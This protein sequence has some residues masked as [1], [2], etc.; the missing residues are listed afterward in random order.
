MSKVFSGI[1]RL[2]NGDSPRGI[3]KGTLVLE[4]GAFRGV[5]GEGVLDAMLEE[6]LNLETVIG[7]SAGALNGLNYA[8]GQIG[9]SARINLRYRHDPRYVGRKALVNNHGVIGF[10]FVFGEFAR[11]VDIFNYERFNESDHR[12]LAVATSLE[13]GR[14]V[15][16]ERGRCGDIFKAIQASA[17]MPYI[18]EPVEVD[19]LKCLDGGCS[20]KIPYA[21]ALENEGAEGRVVIVKTLP[22]DYRRKVKPESARAAHLVYGKSHPEFA[23]VLASS[24]ERANA[25]CDEIDELEKQ[26]RAFVIAPSRFIKVGRLE[27]DMEKLGALYYLGYND[28]KARMAE[29]KEYLGVRG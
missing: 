25:E 14:P 10:D 12:F 29:L 18:S 23:S 13:D 19:G 28:M 6:G 5:Y 11:K 7:V 22:R 2:P 27:K 15:Y 3:V 20:V 16:F 4:G 1:D 8:A 17:S 21:W 24:T 26:G 9:R